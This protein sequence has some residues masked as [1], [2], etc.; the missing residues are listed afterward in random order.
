M[1]KTSLISI[2][3]LVA[4]AL[5]ACAGKP[6]IKSAAGPGA[7]GGANSAQGSGADSVMPPGVR[8]AAAAHWAVPAA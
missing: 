1:R 7:N 3:A 4:L 5:G 6:P 8:E 2:V